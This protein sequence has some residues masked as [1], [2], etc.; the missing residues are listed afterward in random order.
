M[1]HKIFSTFGDSN[2]HLFSQSLSL[3]I[4]RDIRAWNT[5]KFFGIVI[6]RRPHN[7]FL[8]DGSSI[9]TGRWNLLTA[10]KSKRASRDP[11]VEACTHSPLYLGNTALVATKSPDVTW[12][13]ASTAHWAL[14]PRET[15]ATRR[16]MTLYS[17]NEILKYQ[18]SLWFS[19]IREVPLTISSRHWKFLVLFV[20]LPG[21]DWAW[22]LTYPSYYR[23]CISSLG[24]GIRESKP[25][26]KIVLGPERLQARY[27]V[28]FGEVEC[29]T[30]WWQSSSQ[31]YNLV[32]SLLTVNRF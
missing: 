23:L 32:P 30:N 18:T 19:L 3:L 13:F 12:F 20:Q 21:V 4:N 31:S 22:S 2:T 26:L 6:S 8:M 25:V 10:R 15:L 17:C 16:F 11:S 24:C 1:H 7:A 9:D 28:D 27:R 5:C 29:L 14:N